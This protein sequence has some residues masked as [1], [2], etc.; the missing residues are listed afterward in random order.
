MRIHKFGFISLLTLLILMA[1]GVH[2]ADLKVGFVDAER[3]NRE[4]APADE[5][6]KRLE[7]EFQPRVQEIQRREGQIKSLQ[8]Q[9]EKDA[10]TMSE[11]DRRS[12]EQELS[13]QIVDLQR[14]QREF[15]EDLNLRRNQELGGLLERANKIIRQIAESEK[16]DLILQ[17]AVYRSPRVDITDRVLKALAGG[18]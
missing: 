11:N 3:V 16:Y 18:K 4:S 9:F 10:L 14:L 7:K 15:Q 1:G 8:A 13:R 6:S 5:A 17:E 12:R 2:A